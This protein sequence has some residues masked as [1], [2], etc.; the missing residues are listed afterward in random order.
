MLCELHT[1][2]KQPPTPR[3]NA[4]VCT[5]LSGT[6]MLSSVW[7]PPRCFIVPASVGATAAGACRLRG[8]PTPPLGPATPGA[9]GP[10]PCSHDSRR[11]RGAAAHSVQNLTGCQ[12]SVQLHGAWTAEGYR[13]DAGGG[14]H[15]TSNC[16]P[17]GGKQGSRNCRAGAVPAPWAR[18]Q[19]HSDLAWNIMLLTRWLS[20]GAECSWPAH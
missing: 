19:V 20:E 7:L 4:E 17:D 10:A 3:H 14:K 1:L 18:Q 6:A 13:A 5:L 9:S 8:G 12:A 2:H 16:R 15:A 11:W